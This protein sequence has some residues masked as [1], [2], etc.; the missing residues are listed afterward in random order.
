MSRFDHIAESYERALARYPEART[1]EREILRLLDVRGHERVLEISSGSGFLTV[2]LAPLLR[3]GGSVLC[4]D[5]AEGMVKLAREKLRARGL[6][7]V[8]FHLGTDASLPGLESGTFDKAVC[9][10]GFHHV[11]DP[12]RLFRAVARLL[13]PGGTFVVGDF[14][15]DSPVQRYFDERVHQHTATGHQG[16]FLSRSQMVNLGRF[17]GL[18]VISVSRRIAPFSFASRAGVAE[19]YQLVHGLDQSL[20]EV[21]RDVEEVL[22]V[23]ERDG[24]LIVPMDY[25]YAKYQKPEQPA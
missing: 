22:G 23:E 18:D 2:L 7:N 1:D 11:E 9:L 13:R 14:A 24:A 5:V 20:D 25:V 17:A 21:L 16:L 10:G 4:Y 12:V 3:G 15:D 19:F 8:A 6:D